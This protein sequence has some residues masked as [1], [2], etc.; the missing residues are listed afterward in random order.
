MAVKT[1]DVVP[2]FSAELSDGTSVSLFQLLKSGP[3]VLFFYPKAFTPGCTAQSC[4][5]RD[6]SE[7]LAELGARPIGISSDDP[8][9]L[10]SFET[11]NRLGYPLISDADGTIAK[12]FG[13][14]RL[15]MPFARR[16]TFVIDKDARILEMIRDELDMDVHANRALEVLRDHSASPPRIPAL[17]I[18][19]S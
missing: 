19:S 8:E 16:M 7:E 18:E 17:E 2:D 5:F 10:V 6:V 3:I 4:R 11:K 13:A 14:K 9:T 12:I 15:G 1:G